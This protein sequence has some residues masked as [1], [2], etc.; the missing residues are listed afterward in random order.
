MR[1][2]FVIPV[3]ASILILGTLASGLTPSAYAAQG[4]ITFVNPADKHGMIQEDGTGDVYQ[5]QIPQGLADQN[6]EPQVNDPVTFTPGPGQTASDVTKVNHPPTIGSVTVTTDAEISGFRC[7]ANDVND[8]DGD[9][10][11][12]TLSDDTSNASPYELDSNADGDESTP[13]SAST[14]ESTDPSPLS[15][16][17]TRC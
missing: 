7:T 9:D 14:T 15:Q 11:L 13:T 17:A 6:Y 1:A 10:V 8:V 5:F 4:T 12:N 2:Q 16:R 3:L